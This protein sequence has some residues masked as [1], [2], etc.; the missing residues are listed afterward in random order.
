M[1]QERITDKQAICLMIG[2]I[3]GSSIILGFAGTARQSTWVAGVMGLILFMP[4]AL[5]YARLLYLYPGKDLFQIMNLLLG[6]TAGLILSLIYTLY[7]LHLGALVLRDVGE[8]LR[9]ITMRKTPM[10]VIFLFIIMVCIL[11]VRVGIEGLGRMYAYI[12]PII[13]AIMIMI[14]VMGAL[15]LNP[16]FLRPVF[17]T[18]VKVLLHSAYTIFSFPFAETVLLLGIFNALKGGSS[19]YKVYLTGYIIG[20][21]LLVMVT[22]TNTLLIGPYV[23]NSYFPAYIAISRIKI[24]DF[25]EHL[26]VTVTISFL[27]SI[28]IKSTICLFTAV[29]GLSSVFKLKDSRPLVVQTGLI[30]V[31]LAIMIFDSTKELFNWTAQIYP[32]YAFPMQVA[33]PVLIWLIAEI[34][35]RKRKKV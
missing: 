17:G 16:D 25:F 21:L 7:A 20:G 2:F 24:G 1:N 35:R 15:Q 30:M 32:Y 31:W 34:S 13:V 8:F 29:R 22:I 9:S 12:L 6:R 33:F 19:P 5:I 23:E 14:T 26:E 28:V 4:F 11:T 27:A 3:I 10:L 18:D